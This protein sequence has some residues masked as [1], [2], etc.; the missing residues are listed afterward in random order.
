MVMGLENLGKRV[1]KVQE[2][3]NVFGNYRIIEMCLESTGIRK[4]LRGKA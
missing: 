3:G 2:N 1:K 4:T